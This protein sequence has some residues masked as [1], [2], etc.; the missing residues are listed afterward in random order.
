MACDKWM[1]VAFRSYVVFL[2]TR[3]HSEPPR[4]EARAAELTSERSCQCL[5]VSRFLQPILTAMLHLHAFSACLAFTRSQ[6]TTQ[7]QCFYC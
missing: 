2:Q 1:I 7:K 5:S 3:L 4:A 6:V